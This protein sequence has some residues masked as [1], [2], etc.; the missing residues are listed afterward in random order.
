MA[1]DDRQLSF[2]KFVLDSLQLIATTNVFEVKS[3]KVSTFRKYIDDC[4]QIH[5]EFVSRFSPKEFGSGSFIGGTS[6]STKHSTIDEELEKQVKIDLLKGINDI[7]AVN[8]NIHSLSA[9]INSIHEMQ[10]AL[11]NQ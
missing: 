10:R 11:S 7:N 1:E 3:D 2:Q 4:E 8:G 6:V 9:V 5:S